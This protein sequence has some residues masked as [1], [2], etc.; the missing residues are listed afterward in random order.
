MPAVNVVIRK[1]ADDN[2][3]MYAYE[4]DSVLETVVIGF[5]TIVAAFNAARDRIANESFAA[6]LKIIRLNVET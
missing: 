2:L 4:Q 3:W 5:P 1:T 6:Q